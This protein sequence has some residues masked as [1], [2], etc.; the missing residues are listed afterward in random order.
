M[1]KDI[2]VLK[3]FTD[4]QNELSVTLGKIKEEENEYY[5]IHVTLNIFST[6]NLTRYTFETFEEAKEEYG[7]IIYDLS[8]KEQIVDEITIRVLG[9]STR[10]F[11]ALMRA[12]ITTLSQ[13]KNCSKFRLRK[14]RNLGVKCL[15]EIEQ[16]LKQHGYELEER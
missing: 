6:N 15:E 13:L 3:C 9:L 2:K 10:A 5:Y 7:S 11:N 4:Y 8:N 12:K 16:A 14:I 1:E